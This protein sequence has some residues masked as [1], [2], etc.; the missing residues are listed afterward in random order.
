VSGLR[1]DLSKTVE[2]ALFNSRALTVATAAS[3]AF[4]S[5]LAHTVRSRAALRRET[6]VCPGEPLLQTIV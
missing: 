5:S 3:G 1:E 4:L 6:R 2:S